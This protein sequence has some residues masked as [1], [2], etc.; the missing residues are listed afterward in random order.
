MEIYKR[1]CPNCGKEIIHK[2]VISCN[3]SLKKGALCKSCATRLRTPETSKIEKLLDETNESYYWIGFLLADGH[4][5]ENGRIS[6][7]LSTKDLEHLQKYAKFINCNNIKTNDNKCSISTLKRDYGKTLKDKFDIKTNKT[8]NPPNKQ[9]FS[10]IN[11][12]KMISIICGFIDGD[13]HIY[14]LSKR[15]DFAITIKIHSSWLEILNYFS[16]I[17][18]GKESAY[19]NKMG[20]AYLHIGDTEIIKNIKKEIINLDLP[21]MSRKWDNIDL[22]YISRYKTAQDRVKNISQLSKEGLTINEICQKLNLKYN[23]AYGLIQRYN[24]NVKKEKI[25]V[26]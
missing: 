3:K 9:V 14:S 7:T 8:Y 5:D 6:L 16:L 15:K 13:G 26:K 20:Y 10:K 22:S 11:R 4:F 25:Y 24:I 1:I 12:E 19:I 2:N 17:L 23:T 18:I 21:Y